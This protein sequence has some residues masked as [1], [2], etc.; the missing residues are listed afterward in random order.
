[1]QGRS[2]LPPEK[3]PWDALKALLRMSI[4][5]GRID[6]DFDQRL[7]D[8]FIDKVS[9]FNYAFHLRSGTSG[10]FCR[11]SEN[12]AVVSHLCVNYIFYLR[13]MHANSTWC[14]L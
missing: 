2:N 10:Y 1:M 14:T 11:R 7:M 3:V 8:S 9:I 6:N 4:Y 5:G 13:T 12:L